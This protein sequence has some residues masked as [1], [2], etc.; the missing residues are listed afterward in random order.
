M[1]RFPQ[2]WISLGLTMLKNQIATLILLILVGCT[3]NRYLLTPEARL[4][5]AKMF[6]ENLNAGRF[7]A[8]RI[9]FTES[10][11]EQFSSE[12]LQSWWDE[13]QQQHGPFRQWLGEGAPSVG[14]QHTV[15]LVCAFERGLLD[16]VILLNKKGQIRHFSFEPGRGLKPYQLPDY[17]D[18]TRFSIID[19]VLSSS[20]FAL[21]ARW[22][23]PH[24]QG[25][26]A[27]L[28]LVQGFGCRDGDGSIGPNK[29]FRDLA[30]G[31]ASRN[32][33]V[34]SYDKRM[35]VYPEEIKSAGWNV[36]HDIID[37]ALAAV[38]M[39]RTLPGVDVEHI[40]VAGHHLAGT[41]AGEMLRLYPRLA[42]FILMAAP[43][44]PFNS[45]ALHDTTLQKRAEEFPDTYWESLEAVSTT[46][47]TRGRY[48]LLIMQ[49]GL[50]QEID[51]NDFTS[52]QNAF[53]SEQ[54]VEVKYYHGLN[55]YFIAVDSPGNYQRAGHMDVQV[56]NDM[57]TWIQSK[58]N[59]NN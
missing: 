58:F 45:Q 19:T 30:A 56:I 15:V 21:P 48:P 57:A 54:R 52:W 41:L 22:F 24:G 8:A 13:V 36:R 5:T 26:F 28:V 17:A 16:L 11:Q 38:S 53:S 32:I 44:P 31:L 47:P 3:G 50:D 42:G 4:S 10:L 9:P 20:G 7:D 27:A 46:L 59:P 39:V 33:A 35:R 43:F 2:N 34:F 14:S 6:I 55:H 49:G 25:P 51:V 40:Y 18:S 12:Q 29:P 23:K 1:V 37:D